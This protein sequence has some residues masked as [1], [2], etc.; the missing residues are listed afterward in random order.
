MVGLLQMAIVLLFHR[1]GGG[2]GIFSN[3]KFMLF[4]FLLIL[5]LFLLHL[6]LVCSSVSLYKGGSKII[7]S[8][9]Q[10][11]EDKPPKLLISPRN[12]QKRIE[13]KKMS[14]N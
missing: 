1:K 10:K 5:S 6:F 2:S 12:A 14:G 13:I 3:A 8:F 4:I 11:R 7:L 9:P